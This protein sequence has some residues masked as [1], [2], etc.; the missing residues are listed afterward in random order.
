MT[1]LVSEECESCHGCYN[2]ETMEL[3]DYSADRLVKVWLCK[4][5]F[6]NVKRIEGGKPK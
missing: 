5:C 1:E 4:T 3:L 2:V 6:E